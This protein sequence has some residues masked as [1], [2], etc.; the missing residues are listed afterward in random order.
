V[1]FDAVG[2]IEAAKLPRWGGF[3]SF[4]VAI[5]KTI[6]LYHK[7]PLIRLR[8]DGESLSQRILMVS[9]MNGRR[10]GG[11]FW[12]APD[13]AT[14]DGHFDICVVRQVPRRRVLTLVPHFLRGTQATQPEIT[15]LRAAELEIHALEGSLPA[16][17]D[18]EILS[19]EDRELKIMLLPKALAV[20]T[21]RQGR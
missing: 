3:L 16:Q 2:T 6:F 20:I 21:M 9:V 18:G 12:M 5:I 4:L 1:G 13:S 10:L 7:G 14:D 19:V 17:T 15:S 8:Y 11:G